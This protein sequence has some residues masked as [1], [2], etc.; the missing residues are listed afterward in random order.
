MSTVKSRQKLVASQMKAAT[1]II[2][3]QA[4][5]H[6][7][8]SDLTYSFTPASW[9]ISTVNC[10]SQAPLSREHKL[11]QVTLLTTCY[12]FTTRISTLFL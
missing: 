10:L 11:K 2:H 9:I 6:Y 3:Q 12:C 5:F 8:L 7:I 4:N 1:S